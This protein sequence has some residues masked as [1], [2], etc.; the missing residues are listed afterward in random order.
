LNT[1]PQQWDFRVYGVSAQ[2]G[3]YDEVKAGAK[4]TQSAEDLRVLDL[5]STRI[6]LTDGTSK[7]HDLTVPLAWLMK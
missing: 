2:G 7:S 5:P 4:P 1:N 3:D 6:D